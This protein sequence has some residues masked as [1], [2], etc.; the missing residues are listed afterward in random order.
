MKTQSIK[1][2]HTS[3][4]SSKLKMFALQRPMGAYYKLIVKTK[5]TKAQIIQINQLKLSKGL[6]Q[7]FLQ[8]EDIQMVNRYTKHNVINYQEL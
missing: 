5:Q 6:E 2:K 1:D 8:K 4:I 3:R 7:K